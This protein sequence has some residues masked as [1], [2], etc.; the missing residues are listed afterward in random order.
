MLWLS[1]HGFTAQALLRVI[2]ARPAYELDG[3]FAAE[4]RVRRFDDRAHAAFPDLIVDRTCPRGVYPS[5]SAGR[6]YRVSLLN[7]QAPVEKRR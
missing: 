4:R 3:Y 5:P 6:A 2:V 7:D 1:S